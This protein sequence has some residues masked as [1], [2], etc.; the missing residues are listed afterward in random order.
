MTI[1]TWITEPPVVEIPLNDVKTYVT[2]F[3]EGLKGFVA[4]DV[5]EFTAAK[6]T[7][8][9]EISNGF[10]DSFDSPMQRE[11]AKRTKQHVFGYRLDGIMVGLIHITIRPG[12]VYIEHVVGHAGTENAGDI[13]IEYILQFSPVDPP[14]AALSAAGTQPFNAYKKIGFLPHDPKQ[15]SGSMTLNLNTDYAKGF[16]TRRGPKQY[17]LS[18]AIHLGYMTNSKKAE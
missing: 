11:L 6:A 13:L 18:S 4:A 15:T 16:W 1:Y 8:A 12:D 17:K 5:G 7:A 3:Q 10:K 14:I 9:I 2:E